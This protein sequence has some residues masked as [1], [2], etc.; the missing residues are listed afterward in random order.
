[1][2]FQDGFRKLPS[3]ERDVYTTEMIL[4]QYLGAGANNLPCLIINAGWFGLRMIWQF[5][6]P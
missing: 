2:L 5:K 4:G 1:M 3:W 6:L